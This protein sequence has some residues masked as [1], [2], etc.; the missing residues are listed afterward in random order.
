MAAPPNRPPVTAGTVFAA[1]LIAALVV[2]AVLAY[3]WVEYGCEPGDALV[4]VIRH[5]TPHPLEG[6]VLCAS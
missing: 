2:W 3:Q 4:L 5:G 6:W 1:L